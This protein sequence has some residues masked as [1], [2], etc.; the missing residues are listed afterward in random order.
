MI[1]SSEFDT[2]LEQIKV[3]NREDVDAVQWLPI[4]AIKAGLYSKESDVYAF[5]M[6]TWEV[7]SAFGQEGVVYDQ[8]E[9]RELTC[10]PFNYQQSENILQ[11]LIE[12]YIPEK[13]AKCPDWFY[14]EITRPCLLHQKIDRP[15]MKTI[16]QILQTRLHKALPKQ[17]ISNPSTYQ[18]LYLDSNQYEDF[19][20]DLYDRSKPPTPVARRPPPPLPAPTSVHDEDAYDA[21]DYAISSPTLSDSFIKE[22]K[23]QDPSKDQSPIARRP[24]PPPPVPMSY[25]NITEMKVQQDGRGKFQLP[26]PLPP[27][28]LNLKPVSGPSAP[29]INSR[30]LEENK[31]CNSNANPLI[32]PQSPPTGLENRDNTKLSDVNTCKSLPLPNIPDSTNN[33][34]KSKY[35][36][37]QDLNSKLNLPTPQNRHPNP[38]KPTKFNTPKTVRT[39]YEDS[40]G[41]D[42][43]NLK[44]DHSSDTKPS[45]PPSVNQP[46]KSGNLSASNEEQCYSDTVSKSSDFESGIDSSAQ[47]GDTYKGSD[48]YDNGNYNYGNPSASNEEQCYSDTVSK[49]SDF[50]SEIDSS[51]QMGDTYKGSDFYETNLLARL[52]DTQKG[53][54]FYEANPLA[55]HSDTQ[56]GS[57]FDISVGVAESYSIK[58]GGNIPKGAD[59]KNKPKILPKPKTKPKTAAYVNIH[60]NEHDNKPT[61]T[62]LYVNENEAKPSIPPRNPLS[63]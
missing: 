36:N 61:E 10:I 20:D 63:K 16:L 29:Q 14:Q 15:S 37:V 49:S 43:T 8:D 30:Q 62:A 50:E 55:K 22:S 33:N 23:P 60:A 3:E 52:G 5:G 41:N 40:A 47:M 59:I 9:E 56:R 51:A 53:S 31:E 24:P 26:P 18:D 19:Y 6:I 58:S 54:D 28:P 2:H 17:I 38:P 34:V 1:V 39:G 42:E 48:F 11:H 21:Y 12:G 35:P 57:N 32:T 13:P 46:V 45:A 44:P 4:E 25:Y 7:M 27:K